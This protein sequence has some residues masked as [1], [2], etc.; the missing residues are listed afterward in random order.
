MFGESCKGHN[1]PW[2]TNFEQEPNGLYVFLYGQAQD[3]ISLACNIPFLG[4]LYYL[5][6]KKSYPFQDLLNNERNLKKDKRC[7]MMF[8]HM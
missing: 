8:I 3:L 7:N 1:N 6:N 4:S 2:L 5:K